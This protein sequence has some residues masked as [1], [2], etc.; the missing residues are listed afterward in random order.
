MIV[1]QAHLV[2]M[3]L[4]WIVPELRM[5]SANN[6]RGL[7]LQHD[8]RRVVPFIIMALIIMLLLVLTNISI[9]NTTLFIYLLWIHYLLN[10][11]L[12]NMEK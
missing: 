12:L 11:L 5:Q 2:L 7:N 9:L 4:E 8:Y 6:S 1:K 3:S 10:L